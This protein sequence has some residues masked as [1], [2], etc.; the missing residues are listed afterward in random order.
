MR[1]NTLAVAALCTATLTICSCMQGAPSGSKGS[2]SDKIEEFFDRLE[3]RFERKLESLE[4]KLEN[5]DFEDM[6]EHDIT[7]RS[8]EVTD[9]NAIVVNG[10]FDVV[11]TQ[12]GT[13]SAVF[14]ADSKEI[15]KYTIR[16]EGKTLRIDPVQSSRPRWRNTRL[17]ISSTGLESI[18]L[19]GAADLNVK[20]NS[21]MN[22]D[23]KI[24][25]AAD[26][27]IRNL[28]ACSVTLTV[29]GAAD[30]ELKNLNADKLSVTVNGAADVELEGTAGAVCIQTNGI[31]DIDTKKLNYNTIDI[32]RNGVKKT[33]ER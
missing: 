2:V 19:N 24:S 22:F 27:S 28:S 23:M 8:I 18:V 26:A 16:Q 25:G 5:M 11:F 6:K 4:S 21:V 33:P 13:P 9:F 17:V 1:K 15:D 12:S 30:L 29:N 14:S 3:E 20:D 7:S 32:Q 31:S 10:A